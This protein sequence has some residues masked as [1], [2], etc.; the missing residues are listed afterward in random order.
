MTIFWRAALF[1]SILALVETS[2]TWLFNGDWGHW[3]EMFSAQ[4]LAVLCFAFTERRN[5]H[6]DQNQDHRA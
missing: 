3:L 5:V 6:A 2:I 4:S 1:I